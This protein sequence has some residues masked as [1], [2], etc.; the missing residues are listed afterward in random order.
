MHSMRASESASFPLEQADKQ[1]GPGWKLMKADVPGVPELSEWLAKLP[2]GAR[3]GIDPFV[4]TNEVSVGFATVESQRC[5][6]C[7]IACSSTAQRLVD[8]REPLK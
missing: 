2:A 3:V 6:F 7:N 4:H 8:Y 1:L 5:S